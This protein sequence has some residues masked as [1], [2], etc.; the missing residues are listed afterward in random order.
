MYGPA[1]RCK[2]FS[3]I[4]QMRSCINVSGLRL[5]RCDLVFEQRLGR[6]LYDP[7]GSLHL[8]VGD[9]SCVSWEGV[10]VDPLPLHCLN[11]EEHG[12]WLTSKPSLVWVDGL[13][14]EARMKVVIPSSD[15]RLVASAVGTR[16]RCA[17]SRPSAVEDVRAKGPPLGSPSNTLLRSLRSYSATLPPSSSSSSCAAHHVARCG[18]CVARHVAPCQAFGHRHS[19]R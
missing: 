18:L 19:F 14:N 9:C 1:V 5:E 12:G 11:N 3:S 8:R 7:S 2:R 13:A 6:D 17:F 10:L 16:T 15:E 4:W